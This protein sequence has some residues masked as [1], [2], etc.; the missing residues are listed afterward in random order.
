[1]FTIRIDRA[2]GTHES[3]QCHRYCVSRDGAEVALVAPPLETVRLRPGDKAFIMNSDGNTV[4]T[5]RQQPV[6]RRA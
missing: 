3:V 5:V 4:D 1:M 2:D 6:A